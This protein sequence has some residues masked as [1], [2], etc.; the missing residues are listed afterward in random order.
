MEDKE[1]RP[2][3]PIRID[4]VADAL[5]KGLQIDVFALSKIVFLHGGGIMYGPVKHNKDN[6]R[7]GA[8]QHTCR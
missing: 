6:V 8:A 5:L 3:L 2:F 4:E 7:H 1:Q